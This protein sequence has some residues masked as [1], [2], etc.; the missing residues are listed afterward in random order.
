MKMVRPSR[1]GLTLGIG[2]VVG[3]LALWA[4]AEPI[5]GPGNSVV[6]GWYWTIASGFEQYNIGC[7]HRGNMWHRC[8]CWDAISSYC[9]SATDGQDQTYGCTGGSLLIGSYTDTVLLDAGASSL[10]G[11]SGPVG[12]PCSSFHHIICNH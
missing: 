8:R 5:L 1:T 10:A 9:G 7:D 4:S 11:C 2:L 6:G 12:T 3:L